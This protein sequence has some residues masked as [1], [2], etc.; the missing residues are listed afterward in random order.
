[1]EGCLISDR[2]RPFLSLQFLI[3]HLKFAYLLSIKSDGRKYVLLFNKSSCEGRNCTAVINQLQPEFKYPAKI[4]MAFSKML[5]I[6][7]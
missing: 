5:A 4:E 2:I 7:S 3:K 6:R 1:M